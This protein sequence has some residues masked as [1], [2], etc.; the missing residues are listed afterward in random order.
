MTVAHWLCMCFDVWPLYIILMLIYFCINIPGLTGTVGVGDNTD[1]SVQIYGHS[2]GRLVLLHASVARAC[3][4]ELF[5]FL[6]GHV[7]YI[8]FHLECSC[9]FHASLC[10]GNAFGEHAHRYSWWDM[11]EGFAVFL[12]IGG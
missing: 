5:S 6:D 1:T 9:L 4:C 11:L 2:V 8:G 12:H 10:D 7:V 3:H